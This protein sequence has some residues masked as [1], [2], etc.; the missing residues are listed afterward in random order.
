M[1]L[2]LGPLQPHPSLTALGGV[3]CKQ[4][5]FLQH[6]PMGWGTGTS[7]LGFSCSA[8]GRVQCESSQMQTG[9]CLSEAVELE[10]VL[11]GS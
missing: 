2:G 5:V 9:W 8:Q 6:A 10:L 1:T 3:C 7:G 4:R 11:C